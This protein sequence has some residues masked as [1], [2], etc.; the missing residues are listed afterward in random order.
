MKKR[1]RRVRQSVKLLSAIIVLAVVLAILPANG[2]LAAEDDATAKILI[3]STGGDNVS[4]GQTL[5]QFLKNSGVSEFAGV[6]SVEV[7]SMINSVEHH[8]SAE[9]DLSQYAMVVVFLPDYDLNDNDI[10]VL[11]NF[12]KTGGRVVM[13]G[14]WNNPAFV[15]SNQYLSKAGEKL[16]AQ[17]TITGEDDKTKTAGIINTDS[18]ILDGV[19]LSGETILFNCLAKIEYSGN[20]EVIATST[21]KGYPGIVDLA[22]GKGRITAV[23]D[24][25]WWYSTTGVSKTA[26][27]DL[28]G[29][30]L[31][32]SIKNQKIV[33]E[34]GNPNHK[35]A[36]GEK[37]EAVDGN[38]VDKGTI[39]W[40]SCT[41]EE[42]TK[43]LDKEGN[44]IESID[45]TIDASNHKGTATTWIKTKTAH[46][47]IYDCCGAVKTKRGAHVYGKTGAKR[48]TCTV[49]GYVDKVKKS[50]A[51][52]DDI[53]KDN[54]KHTK[55][56]DLALNYKFK[57]TAGKNVYVTWGSVAGADGYDIYMTY[58]GNNE[59]KLVKSLKAP[60]NN[61]VSISK[62]GG[63]IIDQTQ[64]VRCYVTAYKVYNG[65]KRIV[66]KTFI[67]HGAGLKNKNA[68][69]AKALILNKYTYSLKKGLSADIKA[70]T[71]KKISDRSLLSKTHA[72]EFRYISS[73]NNIAAVS[74]TGKI[75]ATGKGTCYVYVYAINGIARTVK[76]TVK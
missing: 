39:E 42:C 32:N 23:S 70:T 43:Y 22:A 75:T 65:K 55:A 46:K 49:C 33:A 74:S 61:I 60:K 59:F 34:G 56:K 7:N 13:H 14:E 28:W 64:N 27:Q 40:Y 52:Q 45:G 20:A 5:V 72:P 6:G 50:K 63:K 12:L 54:S 1:M 19:A 15:D 51:D 24:V 38:C 18:D 41:D 8:F 37:H 11:E 48:Y 76:V 68:T 26:A 29:R 57:V 47:E 67:G 9:D 36:V 25:N 44:E 71:V 3:W 16:G 53:D 4:Y 10:A 31:K 66:A 2:V 58:C 62:L 73:N 69:D 30:I 17:F 35:H 21:N